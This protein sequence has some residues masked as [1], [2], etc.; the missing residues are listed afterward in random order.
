MQ[1]IH[2]GLRDI[3]D[4]VALENELILLCLRLRDSDT[5]KHVYMPHNLSLREFRSGPSETPTHLL[6]QEV[7]NLKTLPAVLNDAVDRE[8]GIY[9]THLVLEAL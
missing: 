9:G 7:P 5:V 4:V 1:L 6:P 8:M 3:L 2:T